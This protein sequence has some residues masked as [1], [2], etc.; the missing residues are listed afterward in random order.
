MS[1]RPSRHLFRAKAAYLP[2]STLTAPTTMAQP[3]GLR[4]QEP[5]HGGGS[6][7]AVA[8]TAVRTS[9]QLHTDSGV[10]V[11]SYGYSGLLPRPPHPPTVQP[12]RIK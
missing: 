7:K 3:E 2:L 1:Q 12:G 4:L 9:L 11:V 5:P 8:D 10:A 6:T